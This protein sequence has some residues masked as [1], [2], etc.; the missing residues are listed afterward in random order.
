MNTDFSRPFD[1]QAPAAVQASGKRTAARIAAP[2][3]RWFYGLIVPIV[4]GVALYAYEQET[5]FRMQELNLFLPGSTFYH[6]FEIY[7][8]GALEWAACFF[9]QFFTIRLSAWPCSS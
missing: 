3:L 9:T 1:P 8:G 7:P 5:L 4:L 6:T 2:L